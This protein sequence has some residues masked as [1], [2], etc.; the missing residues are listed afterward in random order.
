MAL[1]GITRHIYRPLAIANV[2]L[3]GL[4]PSGASTLGEPLSLRD[5][6]VKL[7]AP[8]GEEWLASIPDLLHSLNVGRCGQVVSWT[9]VKK[10]KNQNPKAF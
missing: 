5:L 2:I 8:S 6:W 10:K 7:W 3:E 4:C 1:G 9:H